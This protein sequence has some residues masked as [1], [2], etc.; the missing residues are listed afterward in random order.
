MDYGYEQYG[1]LTEEEK[2]LLADSQGA[3]QTY[4]AGGS[5]AGTALG[6]ALGILTGGTLV[7]PLAAA[8]G[9]I[10]GGAGGLIGGKVAN[11]ANE[12]LQQSLLE[13]TKKDRELQARMRVLD[14][15]GWLPNFRG[16]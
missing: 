16:R 15:G 9:A 5:A 4:A 8:G 1:D 7:V 12:K 10:G 3:G 6:A 2:K 13:K 11:D 14:E